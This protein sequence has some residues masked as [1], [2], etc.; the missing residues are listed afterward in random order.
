MDLG[1]LAAERRDADRVLEQPA[2][3]QWW[4]SG[5]AGYDGSGASASARVTTPRSASS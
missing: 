2:G 1:E 3:V 4:P 5:V